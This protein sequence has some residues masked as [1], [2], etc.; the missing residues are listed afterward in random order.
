VTE[1]Y[2][3]T[4]FAGSTSQAVAFFYEP[5]RCL[6]V[7][8]PQQ[9]RNLPNRPGPFAETLPLSRPGLINVDAPLPAGFLERFFGPEP[10]H[11]WCYYFLQAD[12][13]VQ[14]GNYARAAALGDQAMQLKPGLTNTTASELVP[15]IIGYAH[16]GQ[17]SR[18]MELSLQAARLSDK[19]PYMLCDV[20][21]RLDQQAPAAP[22]KQ[23]AVARAYEKFQ[24]SR[25]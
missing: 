21:S 6:R 16:S 3:A 5:P 22:E 23:P 2:R 9:D 19:M 18:A 25:P 1:S 13:A 10:P 20:W 8:D 15:F 17:W 7:I 11:D 14:S 12:L 4:R 24:C